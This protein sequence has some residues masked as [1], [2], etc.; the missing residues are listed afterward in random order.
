[1]NEELKREVALY[2]ADAQVLIRSVKDDT[3][4]QIAD[5]EWFYR[6]KR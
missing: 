4:K 3:P 2:Q 5:I 6:A 1:M